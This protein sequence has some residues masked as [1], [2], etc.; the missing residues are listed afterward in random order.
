MGTILERRR[1]REQYE[2]AKAKLATNGP[3]VDNSFGNWNRMGG[4]EDGEALHA[5]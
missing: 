4:D 5:E 3:P 1:W 2:R